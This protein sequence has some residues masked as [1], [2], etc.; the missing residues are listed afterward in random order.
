MKEKP[1]ATARPRSLTASIL[2]PLYARLLARTDIEVNGSRDWDMQVQDPRMW[3]R[4]AMHGSLGFGEAYVDGWWG[5]RR[6]DEFFTRIIYSKVNQRIVNIPRR[7]MSGIAAFV[8]LQSLRS[9]GKVGKLHYDLSNE[10]YRAMLGERM[11]YTCG[12]WRNAK[13]A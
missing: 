10:L 1:S 11:V 4:L 12:Y 6:L 7:L 5:A 8:N 2:E 3:R 9:A 13:N